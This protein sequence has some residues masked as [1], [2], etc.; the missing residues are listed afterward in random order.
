MEAGTVTGAVDYDARADAEALQVA[1]KGIVSHDTNTIIDIVTKRNNQQRV[2][3]AAAFRLQYGKD[4]VTCIR[5]ALM[6]NLQEVICGLFLPPAFYDAAQ[7]HDAVKGMGTDEAALIEIICTRKN[8][9]LARIVTAYQTVYGTELEKDISADTSGVLRRILLDLLHGKREE[10]VEVNME[11]AMGDA[12]SLVEA[13]A[14]RWGSD[15]S[16]FA[17][18]FT[19]RSYPQLR[20]V[21]REFEIIFKKDIEKAISGELTML[22]DT[23]QILTA[24][25]KIAK[26]KHR[27]FAEE[28]HRS[29]KGLGTNDKTLIR[30][31]VTR[32]EIDLR[33]IMDE[34]QNLYGQ[35]L[36]SWISGDTSGDYRKILLLLIG[37][38]NASK[39]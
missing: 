36:D 37:Q 38:H 23:A 7:L 17:N 10:A 9:D 21:F 24:I 12:Q 14:G 3:I 18:I 35:S 39:T 16:L 29:M 2:A 25:A 4:L 20:M 28:L 13:V 33:N 8:V 31:I 26:N 5:A 34:F 15:S 22:F 11:S 32:S 1:L 19:T 6:G 27:Y 30:I